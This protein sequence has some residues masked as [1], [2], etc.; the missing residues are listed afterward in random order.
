MESGISEGSETLKH[1]SSRHWGC[2][3]VENVDISF[4]ELEIEKPILKY[5]CFFPSG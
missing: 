3:I 4:Q 2:S 5:F 1:P